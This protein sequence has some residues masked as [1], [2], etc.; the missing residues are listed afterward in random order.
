MLYDKTSNYYIN[1]IF[2]IVN[3]VVIE[4]NTTTH[5]STINPDQIAFPNLR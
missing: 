4:L 5:P 3:E 2:T 1:Q